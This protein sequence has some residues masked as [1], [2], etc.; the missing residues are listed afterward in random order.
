MGAHAWAHPVI[1]RTNLEICGLE[2][3]KGALDTGEALVGAHRIVGGE[4]LGWHIGA[5][6]VEAVERSLLGD[7]G[8]IAREAQ[9]VVGDG[10]I[11]VLTDLAVADDLAN[12]NADLVCPAQGIPLAL[13]ALLNVLQV[14]LGGIEQF[15]ALASAFVGES[16]VRADDETLA[17]KKLLAF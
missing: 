8:L 12:S 7:R 11:E 16:V 9:R 13:D 17:G 4:R 6:H 3:A 15:A 1:D 2:A 5:Q 14:L 10:D